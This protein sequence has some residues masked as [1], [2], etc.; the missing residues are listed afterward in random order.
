M[1]FEVGGEVFAIP[2]TFVQEVALPEGLGPAGGQRGVECQAF[3]HRG[4]PLAALHLE[5]LF[6]YTAGPASA[7][8]RVIVGSARGR[9]F[10]LIVDGVGG[11]VECPP[12]GLLPV[13]EG[14]SELPAACFRG[15]WCREGQVVVVLDAAGLAGLDCV[16]RFDEADVAPPPARG[17]G[18]P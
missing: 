12:Q 8:G 7:A 10:G 1:V 16:E 17:G 3:T 5:R 11:V 18:V 9:Q 2:V 6:G 15:I 13:P 4:T 14:A